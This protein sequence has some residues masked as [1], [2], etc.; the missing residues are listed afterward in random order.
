MEHP[1]ERY[2][3]DNNHYV[4][5]LDDYTNLIRYRDTWDALLKQ[6]G[7]YEPFLCFDWF[8]IWLKYFIDSSKCLIFILYENDM[9]IMLAPLLI[10]SERYKNIAVVRKIELIGN[11]YSPIKSVIF[12]VNDRCARADS[13]QYLFVF[14]TKIFRDWDILE[15]DSVPEELIP[16]ELLEKC[17]VNVGLSVHKFNCFGDWYLDGIDYS[18]VDYFD[19]MP[20]KIRNE[21][22]RRQKRIC[23][24]GKVSFEIG[25]DP[26]QFP[27]YMSQ[28]DEVR[29]KSWKK[30]EQDKAFLREV[31]HMS[32]SKGWLR[33]GFLY[34]DDV[35]I[36]AQIRYVSNGTAYFMEALHD[37]RYDKYGPGNLL[38]LKVIEHLID[39]ERISCIDQM[40]GDEPYKEYWTPFQRERYGV[41]VFNH[42]VKGVIFN[43]LLRK[44]YPVVKKCRF[45][46]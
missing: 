11:H 40:R 45:S 28:Y 16:S 3:L 30:P 46:S 39:N 14:L 37:K 17:A 18:S 38:R 19:R 35:P 24:I 22:K 6:H 2:T 25:S 8:F 33:S 13:L 41:T 10:K 31:R 29:V 42:T 9:P 20:K 12:G 1:R 21:L 4:K 32:I 36:A 26:E 43:L 44:L 7:K 34:V 27:R 23:E 15:L 5:I